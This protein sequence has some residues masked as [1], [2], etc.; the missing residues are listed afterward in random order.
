MP[1][2]Y[3]YCNCPFKT[4]INPIDQDF[5]ILHGARENSGMDAVFR[6]WQLTYLASKGEWTDKEI[7][8]P[9]R[10]SALVVALGSG[11]STVK[12]FD[13]RVRRDAQGGTSRAVFWAFCDALKSGQDPLSGGAPQLMGLYRENAPKIFGIKYGEQRYFLGL[14]LK[15][16]AFDN[17]EW[18][19]ELFHRI[20]PENL[21]VIE[22]AQR[23][24][25]N[26][27]I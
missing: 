2:S 17:I 22:G 11:G 13:G 12:E 3:R 23:H 15:S 10:H 27:E 16:S 8:L 4:G 6:I 19:D 26:T 9:N 20:N 21:S 1:L 18:R 5:Y 14:P 25:R 7:P 24:G